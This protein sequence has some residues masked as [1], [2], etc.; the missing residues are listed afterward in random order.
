[1]LEI[2]QETRADHLAV[3]ELLILAFEGVPHS[4]QQE[5][6]LVE[7]LRLSHSF[8][9]QLSLVA[10]ADDQILGHILL[11][12]VDLEGN[13]PPDVRLL[14]LAPLAVLPARQK[15]GIGAKLLEESRLRALELGYAGI[16]LLGEPAYYGKFGYRP[17][18]A[19]NIKLPLD[20][21]CEYCQGLELFPHALRGVKGTIV[22][23]PAF[24]I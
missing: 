12:E 1:M 8:V 24:G 7:R 23:P 21:P 10:C 4:D 11:S 5:H 18:S 17:L 16:V 6:L 19:F 13:L 9:P 20:V 22:Y 3:K 2:R 14:A 15:Q